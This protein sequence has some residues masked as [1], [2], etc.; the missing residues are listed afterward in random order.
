MKIDHDYKVKLFEEK[1]FVR[2]RC[3]KCG[4]YFWTLDENRKTC[5]DSPCDMYSFIGN[6][7]TNKKYSYTEMV[8]T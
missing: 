2:K 5:G 3:E 8:K 6:P 4:Q 1:G 7:I